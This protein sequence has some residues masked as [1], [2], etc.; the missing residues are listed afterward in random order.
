M[1]TIGKIRR[2]VRPDI[3]SLPASG[4]SASILRTARISS[5]NFVVATG[6]C[7]RH[8]AFDTTYSLQACSRIL[9]LYFFTLRAA[10][11]WRVR[12][13]EDA[14]SQA[15]IVCDGLIEVKD[16]STHVG[17]GHSLQ[18]FLLRRCRQFVEVPFAGGAG[19]RSLRLSPLRHACFVSS[20]RPQVS[21]S[22]REW[23]KD[24]GRS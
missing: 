11:I 4:V 13:L 2:L 23:R 10:A 7:V 24:A 20:L 12:Q 15:V 8:Q 22:W 5:R 9:P 1:S 14:I 19:D 6:L 21:P 18:K 3:S 17:V 16:T